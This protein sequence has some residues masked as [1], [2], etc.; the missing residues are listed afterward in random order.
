M[1]GPAIAI[2]AEI[3]AL[4]GGDGDGDPQPAGLIGQLLDRGGGDRV[5]IA[6]G[7]EQADGE[8]LVLL[9]AGRDHRA[10]DALAVGILERG[11]VAEAA[12]EL[13]LVQPVDD[14][15]VADR[16]RLV[17]I[18]VRGRG[19][20]DRLD[21]EAGERRQRLGERG[22]AERRILD[23]PGHRRE[24]RGAIGARSAPA[25]RSSAGSSGGS[26]SSNWLSGTIGSLPGRPAGLG[27]SAGCA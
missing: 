14:E 11:E 20:R 8:R 4:A 6:F 12:F 1:S 23:R 2:V 21:V 22:V 13:D 19:L 25:A 17:V 9:G 16:R 3:V 18:L 7:A 15:R 5:I 24:R 27:G 26:A 10:V